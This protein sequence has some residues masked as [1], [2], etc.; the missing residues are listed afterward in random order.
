M[1]DTDND[2]DDN[3]VNDAN[4]ADDNDGSSRD[5]APLK[6]RAIIEALLITASEPVTPGRL[7]NLLS[8]YNGRDIREAVDALNAQYEDAGHGIL[9]VEIAGGYQLASRQ[10]YG[11]WLRKYHKTSNQVRLSQAGLEA[12]AI[13]AFKQPVTRIEIDSI[14]GVNSG[15]VLHTLLEVNMVR[16]VGRSE[17][18]GKPMLFGTTREFLV[19]F[20]LK[21]LSELPK[22]KELEELLAEG[23]HKAEA[24]QLAL[25][26]NELQKQAGEDGEEDGESATEE[27]DNIAAADGEEDP[28]N[29]ANAEEDDDESNIDDMERNGSS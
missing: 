16:I 25:E 27:A 3:V 21:G 17:G 1:S 13:V 19:H 28:A 9:V 5:V 18:I 8:G 4:D 2:A 22:P 29:I 23:Q 6:A 24:R 20:G 15:G 11:P 14:R 26:L 10:E 7:T 12:L